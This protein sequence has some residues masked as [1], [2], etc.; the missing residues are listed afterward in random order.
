MDDVFVAFLRG[1]LSERL[2]TVLGESLDR[3]ANGDFAAI[4]CSPHA[5]LL[6]G[7]EDSDKTNGETGTDILPWSDHIS[8]RLD[9]I[10]ADTNQESENAPEESAA[11]K[12]HAVFFVAIAALYAFLQSNVTGPPLPFKSAALVFPKRI[13]KDAT[14]V[15]TLRRELVSS[16]S[17]DG[18]AAYK[19]MPNPELFWLAHLILQRPAIQTAVDGAAW[20]RMRVNFVHQR[21]LSEVAPSLQ[22]S[23]YDD[24]AVLD[25]VMSSTSSAPEKANLMASFLLERAAIHMHHGLDKKARAD[26]DQAARARKFEFALTGLLGKRTKF[27]EKDVSQLVVLARSSDPQV[28][29]SSADVRKIMDVSHP[30]NLHLNDDTLLEAIS[31]TERVSSP[32]IEDDAS[33]PA[34]LTS[35]DPAN[36]P[37]LDPVDSAILLS[38][39]S[40]ITNTSPSDGL[41]REETA[42]YATRVL[43]GGSSNWQVYTQALLVRS[44]IEGYKSR[45]VER[46][47]LQLQALVDQVIAETSASG[48]A[49]NGNKDPDASTFLPRAKEAEA[50]PVRDRLC[51]LFALSCPFRWDLEAEL[52]ARWV[53]LGGLRSALEIYERLEMWA[54]AALCWAATDREDKAARIVRRQLFHATNGDESAVDLE[55]ET[56]EGAARDPP[57][58]DA[59][60]LY[61]ILGD[62]KQLPSFYETAWSISNK[63]YARAQR[64]LGRLYSSKRDF[65]QAAE[66][67]SLSLKVNALNQPAWFSLGCAHLEMAQFKDA[68]GAFSRCVQLD[69]QDAEAWS[70]LAAALVRLRSRD[71]AA[72]ADPSGS[73]G[74]GERDGG[75]ASWARSRLDALKA[76]K[77][78]AVLKHDNYR[79]WSNLLT[80]SASTCPPSYT[81]AIAA[82]RRLCDLRGQTEGDKCI[83]ADI[84]DLL[85][86]HVITSAQESGLN[87]VDT[88][89]GLGKMVFDLATK[90]IQPLITASPRLW[91]TL[92]TLNLHSGRPSSA[93]E[94]QEKA[95]RSAL[96][97]PQWES[98]GEPPWEAVAHQT[99]DLVDAYET[100]GPRERTEG[101]AAGQGEVV[102]KDWKFKA[103]NALRSVMS[104][105]KEVWE[106]SE[107]WVRLEE[108][109]AELKAAD[110]QLVP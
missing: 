84:F 7:H 102:A 58:A 69:D 20:A 34:S 51:Y 9:Q 54:E 79:I 65:A 67:Y 90:T 73:G 106:G 110:Q 78:A 29:G 39:A 1:A 35:L 89:R 50:A 57:P 31:F 21:L 38:V 11:Y 49:Q 36:Q 99:L 4:L 19:L 48:A 68:V 88:S 15:A 52:A 104:K 96:A 75:A 71:P 6:L 22:V 95:W 30:Q 32:E 77:R 93:L 33:L 56:W 27:Q 103:R 53:N 98:E 55:A 74:S 70:N 8:R 2:S 18:V 94:A 26:L 46:G 42:P 91:A 81:D 41:T 76:F 24:L 13:A 3:L 25:G 37:Q 66:A 100:L 40:S 109:L 83:D 101:L 82:Q 43:E 63:R 87:R 14:A 64:S 28:Q 85:V 97:R 44:R 62:L 47:L 17:V 80:A 45:T 5:R 86:R 108:R 92:S 61:C 60:R 105:A 12:Q 72:D 10:L 107:A 59:P 16:L 23:I